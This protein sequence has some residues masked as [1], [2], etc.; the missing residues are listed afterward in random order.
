VF[1]DYLSRKSDNTLRRQAA[2]LKRL[3]EFLEQIGEGIGVSLGAE[4]G[5]FAQAVRTVG[6]RKRDE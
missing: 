1:A 2:D 3:V 5:A 6:I 4:L